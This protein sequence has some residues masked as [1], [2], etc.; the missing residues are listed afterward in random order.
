MQWEAESRRDGYE[1]VIGI[2]EAGRGPLAGPVVA[3][4]VLLPQGRIRSRIDDS[5]KLTPAQRLAAFLELQEKAVFGIG[6][7]NEQVIDVCN[8]LVSARIAMENAVSGLLA[9]LKRFRPAGVHLLVDGI[10]ALQMPYACKTIVRGDARCRSIAAASIIAKVSRDRIMELYDRILPQYGFAQ[11]KGY[12][13]R[14]HREALD[15]FGPSF[16]H[17]K[18]FCGV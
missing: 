8:I 18:T 11:H 12:P 9:R 7:V 1:W 15:R 3:A 14:L 5:K 10:T 17:R 6:V 2:D 4:A 16:I 13:T